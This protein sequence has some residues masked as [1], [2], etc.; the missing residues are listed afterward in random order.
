MSLADRLGFGV[1]RWH[2]IIYLL[3]LFP[4]LTIGGELLL[5]HRLSGIVHD[6][7]AVNKA[8]ESRMQVYSDLGQL[9][10]D[11]NAPGNDVF[12]AQDVD[13]AERQLAAAVS[14][15]TGAREAA[16]AEAMR[17][18]SGAPRQLIVADLDAIGASNDQM[19][20]EARRILAHF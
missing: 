7:V 13:L 20:A 3:A 4:V 5:T 10:S 11:V 12:D 9:A 1:E 18:L 16:R 8:W 2:R 15:F 19:V 17:T 6:A 14:A